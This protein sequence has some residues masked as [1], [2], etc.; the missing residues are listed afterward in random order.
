MTNV[1]KID[2]EVIT[3]DDFVKIL[4]L[5]NVYHEILQDIVNDKLTAHAAA[6]SNISAS[7]EEVQQRA[8]QFRRIEGLHRAKDTIEHL[9]YLGLSVDDFEAY[10]GEQV[11]IGKMLEKVFSEDAIQ[12]YFQLHKSEFESAEV[13]HMILD[14][15]GKA[16][17]ILSQLEDDPSSFAD[18]ARSHSLSAES[19]ANG[20][21]LGR[22]TPGLMAEDV[23]AQVFSAAEGS[24]LGPFAGEEDNLYEIFRVDKKIDANLDDQIR[25][26]IRRTLYGNWLEARAEEH[27]IDIY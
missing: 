15:E 6:K 12:E 13:S 4:K 16:K 7:I 9:D 11:V 25:E 23:D 3:S 8:D 20:G 27:E 14:S 17:E 21:S 26:E 1:A 18:L 10:L 19:A 22:I 24:L 2:K 5:K